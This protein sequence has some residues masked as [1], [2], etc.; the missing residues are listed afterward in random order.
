[1]KAI[2]KSRR[3]YLGTVGL[4]VSRRAA[5]REARVA[6][7]LLISSTLNLLRVEVAAAPFSQ[8][9]VALVLRIGDGLQEFAAAPRAANVLGRAAPGARRG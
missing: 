1:M 9:F 6:R 5:L 4:A 8:F 7:R 3:D 2:G